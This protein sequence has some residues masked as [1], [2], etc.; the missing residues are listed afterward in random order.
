[1]RR[2]NL[3]LALLAWVVWPAAMIVVGFAAL[4]AI[5]FRMVILVPAVAVAPAATLTFRSW[6]PAAT[7]RAGSAPR[8]R[9]AVS[10]LV[11]TAVFSWGLSVL[12]GRYWSFYHLGAP[13]TGTWLLLFV[14]P[15]VFLL[16]SLVGLC[17][18]KLLCKQGVASGRATGF[19]LVS[20]LL[21]VAGLF[22]AE[23]RYSAAER[24]AEGEGAGDLAPFFD[25][26][27]RP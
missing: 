10:A 15:G 7:G 21:I 6:N 23:L 24:G 8:A 16:V 3:I 2:S 13:G 5:P 26:L 12:L 9:L 20:M 17:T 22:A 27:V 19:A 25:S 11:A 4:F 1:M 18:F 14:L